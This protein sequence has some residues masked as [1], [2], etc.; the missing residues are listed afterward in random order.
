MKTPR[1]EARL[2]CLE[3]HGDEAEY[4]AEFLEECASKFSAVRKPFLRNAKVCRERAR[5][6][7]ANVETLRRYFSARG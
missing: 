1:L 5:N 7:R 4:D 2:D 6:N 3:W